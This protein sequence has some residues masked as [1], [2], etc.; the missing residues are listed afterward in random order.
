MTQGSAPSRRRFLLQAGAG[1]AALGLPGATQAMQGMRDIPRRAPN[2]ASPGF[3]PDVEIELVCRSAS[4][5]RPNAS[6]IAVTS[7]S[8]RTWR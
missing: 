5:S 6:R 7:S 4:P 2:R 3:H 1:A 8:T